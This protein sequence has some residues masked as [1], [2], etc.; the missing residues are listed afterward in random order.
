[1]R[2]GFRVRSFRTGGLRRAKHS[3]SPASFLRISGL[4]MGL[5]LALGCGT[6]ARADCL[7]VRERERVDLVPHLALHFGDPADVPLHIQCSTSRDKNA[8]S[9]CVPI[10]AYNLG[11]GVG[12]FRFAL[13][14]PVPPVGFER[15]PGI[16]VADMN[17]DTAT[18]AAI[19]SFDLTAAAPVCGPAFLGCLRLPTAEL[20]ESFQIVMAELHSRD[21]CAAR[22]L[23]GEWHAATLD[24]GG[25]FVGSG[26]SCA[27]DGCAPNAPIADLRATQSGR[28]GLIELSWTRGTGTYT[29]L[30][31]RTD[32]RYPIDPWDG[33]PL[34]FVPSTVTRCS[35]SMPLP[36][37]VRIAGWSISRTAHGDFSSASSLECGS[38]TS[39]TIQLPV[40]ATPT[41]WSAMKTLYR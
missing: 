32:G 22:T 17:V 25:A 26:G 10:Y 33:E 7:L 8:S 37:I 14:T 21:T 39:I 15:G 3:S 41:L 1:M 24:H 18:G 27:A 13:Q 20:P 6:A 38:L 19:T 23:S 4:S 28:A 36:G 31:Y 29:L 30:R 5:L 34:A 11:E 16:L 12:G 40:A 9:L 2:E 35:F